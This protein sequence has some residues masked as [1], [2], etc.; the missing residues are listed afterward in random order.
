MPSLLVVHAV[1]QPGGA[2]LAL[3]RAAPLLI[4]RGWRIT[5]T[6]PGGRRPAAAPDDVLWRQQAVGGL[7]RGRGAAALL[8]Y[9]AFRALAA[10]HDVAYLNGTVPGRLLPALGTGQVAGVAARGLRLRGHV[11]ASIAAPPDVRTVLHVHDMVARVPRFWSAAD[12]LLADSS[13]CAAPVAAALGREVAVTGCPVD[14]DPA[15]V[16]PPWAPDGRPVVAFVGRVEPRKGPLDLIT[17]AEAVRVVVPDARVVVVGDDTYDADP[18]YARAVDRRADAARVERWPW[19]AGG[20]GLL[21]HVDVLVVPSDREPFGTIA[22]EALAVGV[23]VV[24]GAV[25][26]LV[27]VVKDGVTGR[28]VPPHD[29][30]ALAHGIIWALQNG[31]LLREDCLEAARRW[32]LRAVTDRIE[33]ALTGAAAPSLPDAG[34]SD[35]QV[36]HGAVEDGGA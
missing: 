17:A 23:P 4:D 21:R 8:A 25:D 18:R 16:T 1:D 3:L 35:D 14:L 12:A 10:Q 30:L 29:P 33:A 28:L 2:E 31:P 32:S 15:P 6:G 20:P 7:G 24:A 19:Q 36:R 11:D 13:A 26:G 27:E 5:M 9:G 22:A 34:G